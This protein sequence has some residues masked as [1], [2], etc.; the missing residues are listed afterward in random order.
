M[1][2]MAANAF[3]HGIAHT[4]ILMT[5][6]SM[7]GHTQ[8]SA[9]ESEP[10]RVIHTADFELKGDG[11]SAEWNATPWVSIP[12]RLS[13][14]G[15]YTTDLKVLYSDTG[16]YC[17]FRCQDKKI[18]ATLKEDFADLYREDVVEVFF[19]TDESVPVYFEY[20][21]SPL[22]YEL[23]IV[24]PNYKGNFFGWRPWHYEG[25][26]L[27]RHETHIAEG[28]DKTWTAE[29]FIPYALLKPIIPGPPKKGDRWRANFYRI[30]YDTGRSHW[31][32]KPTRKNFHDYESFGTIVFE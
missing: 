20:E 26:R 23:A 28:D 31:S 10:M 1:P 11:S 4:L 29:M 13:E 7:T 32:W 9:T 2:D 6:I 15:K 27:T 18:T 5:S 3:T 22:N 25:E 12:Q 16:I 24:V 14:G 30:D 17:L 19:W 8:P 21:L